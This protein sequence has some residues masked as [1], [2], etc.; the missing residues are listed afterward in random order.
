MKKTLTP[1]AKVKISLNHTTA[2]IPPIDLGA[3]SNSTLTLKAYNNIIEYLEKKSSKNKNDLVTMAKHFQTIEVPEDLLIKL[4]IDFRSIKPSKALNR[5]IRN[6]PDGSYI[7]EWGIKFSPSGNGLYYDISVYPLMD[8]EYED[9]EGFDW[10]DPDDTGYT[11]NIREKARNLFETTD[12]SLVGNMTQAQIFEK[13]WHL[14]GFEKFLM[15]L[16]INKKFAHKLLRIIT[17]IQKS[18][19]ENF[20]KEVGTFIDIFKISDDL[21][22]QTSSFISP[23]TYKE[24]I[25]PYHREL[26]EY[27]KKFT[28]AKIALHCCGDA[29][30]SQALCILHAKD[31]SDL[32]SL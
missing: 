27:A 7:D 9:L 28:D 29:R 32:L 6:F 8:F 23:A 2:G 17:N 22:G 20:L 3:Q 15:D 1:R 16:A 19:I 26:F 18:R 10:L 12:Y 13:C 31:T 30:P 14:R 25:M 4:K 5:V 21:C 24:M 11:Q